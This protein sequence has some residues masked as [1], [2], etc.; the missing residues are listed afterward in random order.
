MTETEKTRYS[1]AELE[2]F[3]T[4]YYFKLKNKKGNRTTGVNPKFL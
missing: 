1:D 3:K 2:E 4:L